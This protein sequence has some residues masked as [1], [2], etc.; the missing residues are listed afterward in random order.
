MLRT[1]YHTA[2]KIF[3]SLGLGQ[4]KFSQV[5]CLFCFC[6]L[7]LLWLF[8]CCCCYFVFLANSFVT[9]SFPG[10]KGYKN[11]I[12]IKRRYQIN[13]THSQLAYENLCWIVHGFIHEFEPILWHFN[14]NEHSSYY[15]KKIKCGT[16]KARS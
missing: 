7:L 2:L 8:C 4:L 10:N 3:M 5:F 6:F 13:K 15:T 1:V 14:N 16:K 9:E 12:L 11:R